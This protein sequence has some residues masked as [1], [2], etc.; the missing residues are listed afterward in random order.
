MG[1]KFEA[2]PESRI[3]AMGASDAKGKRTCFFMEI[4][5]FVFCEFRR[6]KKNPGHARAGDNFNNRE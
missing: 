6:L 3:S 5:E 2:Q 4:S 1:L